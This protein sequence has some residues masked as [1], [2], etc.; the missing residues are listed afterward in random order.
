MYSTY[1]FCNV[2]KLRNAGLSKGSNCIFAN[3]GYCGKKVWGTSLLPQT[4]GH[5]MERNGM[6]NALELIENFGMDN[7]R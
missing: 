1:V 7:G 4:A 3:K 6:K 5:G 2:T